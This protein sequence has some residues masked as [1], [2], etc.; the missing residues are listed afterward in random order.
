MSLIESR[1]E[2][3]DDVSDDL[4]ETTKA[5]PVSQSSL[6]TTNTLGSSVEQMHQRQEWLTEDK[7]I[8]YD[9]RG[10]EVIR[11]DYDDEEVMKDPIINII[12]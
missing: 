1:V 2:Q 10:F 5:F 6:H 8:K 9:D 11:F 12:G 4:Y 7:S 3:L